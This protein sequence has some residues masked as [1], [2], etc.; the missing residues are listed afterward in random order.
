M[1]D[2]TETERLDPAF[3]KLAAILL[4]GVMAVAF[5]STIVNVAIGTLSRD[6]HASLSAT[7]WTVSAYVLALGMVVPV[8][9]WA[10]DRFG[11]K[12]MWLLSLVMFMAGSLLCSS[13]RDI[14]MLIVFRVIQGAGGGL[15]LPI[16]QT[17]LVNAAGQRRLG[18]MMA[19]VGLPALLGPILGPVIGGLIV[20]HLDWRWIFWVNVP[21]SL[22]GLL[23]AWRGL[24]PTPPGRGARL[25]V[26][27]LVLL[28]P[29]LA[30]LIYALSEAGSH[31]GFGSPAVIVPLV[32]GVLTLA[33]FVLYALRAHRP[34]VIDVRLFA[35]RS[36]AASAA[37]LFLSGLFLYGALLLLPLYYEQV[38][39]QTP[40]AAG[41]LLA[42]QGLGMLLTRGQAGKLTDRIGARPVVLS[43]LVLTLAGTI[44]YALAGAHTNEII[45]ALWLVIRGAGIGGVT[46]AI[47][48][49]AYRGVRPAQVPH[50]SSAT[51][52]LQ[53]VGGSFGAAVFA[54]IL[55]TQFTVH[56]HSITGRAA[57]FD[58]AF[59]WSAGLTAVAVA[60]ALLLPA[61][62]ARSAPPPGQDLT[63]NTSQPAPRPHSTPHLSAWSSRSRVGARRD[64]R[65]NDVFQ[66]RRG[67]CQG[68][69]RL[70]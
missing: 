14:G 61:T 34:A 60:A 52:I 20:S 53:Q 27:G 47:M 35:S 58:N 45:L 15:M 66:F 13:A 55:Q 43:S 41:L 33:A 67:A 24:E 31:D 54:V 59:W 7:Q 46:I 51:R 30:A 18:R 29:A 17:L 10:M 11:A 19:V 69:G 28:S 23:L 2:T 22:A 8:S 36:F 25:D 48:A 44:P 9:G 56:A 6:L 50:A 40:L 39:G 32:V 21:F 65:G 70:K 49:T 64:A 38:R 26:T 68:I 37:L 12:Q 62:K 5:D 57:A 1:A 3:I 16:L 63:E 42:P 4:T